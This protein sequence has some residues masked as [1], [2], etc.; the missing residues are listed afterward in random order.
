MERATFYI[1]TAL[2]GSVIPTCSM[3][4]TYDAAQ[5]QKLNSKK[6][7][8]EGVFFKPRKADLC[9]PSAYPVG[10]NSRNQALWGET[11]QL[12]V[13]EAGYNV[14]CSVGVHASI[15]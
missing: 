6:K 2:S 11:R 4:Q 9:L 13:S 1:A 14:V 10:L 8:Q 5:V 7:S 3:L 12:A 15:N